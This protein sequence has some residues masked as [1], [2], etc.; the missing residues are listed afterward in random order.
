M[1][2][3]FEDVGEF[4][5]D[6]TAEIATVAGATIGGLI[7]GPPGVMA[8]TALGAQLGGFVE[9]EFEEPSFAPVTARVEISP[10]AVPL[11]LDFSPLSGLFSS[12]LTEQTDFFRAFLPGVITPLQAEVNQQNLLLGDLRNLGFGAFLPLAE[13]F[14][15]V[16]RSTRDILIPGVSTAS[17]ALFQI[18]RAILTG[19]D[20]PQESILQIF[21]EAMLTIGRTVGPEAKTWLPHVSRMLS[22]VL[23]EVL[24][25]KGRILKTLDVG[26]D[27]DA[28]TMA[29]G[30][31]AAPGAAGAAAAKLGGLPSW[32]GKLLL[33]VVILMVAESVREAMPQL[34]AQ[35]SEFGGDVAKFYFAGM[36]SMQGPMEAV[37]GVASGALFEQLDRRLADVEQ[38]APEDV[39]RTAPELLK[40]AA[41][42]GMSAHMMSV[43]SEAIPT[44]KQLGFPQMA[45]FL[46]DLAQFGG[47]ARN[48]VGVQY[49]TA[50]RSPAL[51][52][53]R[54]RFRPELPDA[55]SMEQLFLE[56][57]IT[58]AEY[59]SYLEQQ[60]WTDEMIQKHLVAVF[61]EARPMDLALALED[62]EVDPQWIQAQL[63]ESGFNDEGVKNMLRA[64]RQRGQRSLRSGL[65]GAVKGA[66]ADGVIDQ[67]LAQGY[68][69]VL[70]LR[71]ESLAMFTTQ[72]GLE[73]LRDEGNEL[74]R[75]LLR[76]AELGQLDLAELDGELA[77]R[78]FDERARLQAQ[79]VAGI[80]RGNKVFQE[81][82][83][84]VKAAMRRAQSNL[85]QSALA[86]H[87]AFALDNDQLAS[88]LLALG[89][90][91]TEV[92]SLVRL[93]AV[94][95]EPVPRL[96]EVLSPE[97]LEQRK[98]DE[99]GEQVLA[100][101]R[102]GVIDESAASALLI[103]LGF[104]P[105][106]AQREAGIVAARRLRPPEPPEEPKETAA[107]RR[108]R[109]QAERGEAER[110][111]TERQD[112]ARQQQLLEDAAR[113]S[114]RRGQ[115][116]EVG[117]EVALLALGLAPGVASA[118]VELEIARRPAQKP[119]SG[120]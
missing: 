26:E 102:S 119:P 22:L 87:R 106:R 52:H 44:F 74:R 40:I 49:E 115:L 33:P 19:Q 11:A 107:A 75:E 43:L 54:R 35:A 37:I 69:Q 89:V 21:R 108:A 76:S 99:L 61:R 103:G 13:D 78:G 14:I 15:G 96:A 47:I 23:P 3:F 116:D 17:L 30:F 48:T 62:S 12:V 32:L 68:L 100:M 72:M 105:G 45:A 5:V 110:E 117:L 59:A 93:A 118:T 4:F 34:F 84:D 28:L 60:G 7:A 53:A 65:M 64:L 25:T 16:G 39:M 36:E 80:R 94:R 114:F 18:I 90:N 111:R 10:S 85:V 31:A 42:L 27:A 29:L 77:A 98:L 79:R 2:D 91:D 6:A 88:T 92:D 109:V 56:R 73:R 67:E 55:A 50:L 120:A 83:A 20:V 46:A 70:A 82:R 112:L 101:Q 71:E 9:A 97:A 58:E 63:A 41:G 113:A 95:R 51:R 57:L 86:A 24:G 81:E 104:E 66:F 8:G 38:V 1:G